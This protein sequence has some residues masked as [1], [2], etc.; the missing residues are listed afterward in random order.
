M[1]VDK[2]TARSATDEGFEERSV[3][4]A[5]EAAL[6]RKLRGPV[7]DDRHAQRLVGYLVR[8]G[9]DLSDAL[10]AIRKRQR[11]DSV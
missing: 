8:Q 3:D 4:E 10:A 7:L 5:L 11:A 6:A 9:F 1:G 2:E